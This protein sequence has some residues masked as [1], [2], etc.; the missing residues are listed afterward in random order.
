MFT[1]TYILKQL[2]CLA[3]RKAPHVETAS[4]T[5][6][7]F[8]GRQTKALFWNLYS[9]FDWNEV[10]NVPKCFFLQKVLHF[11]QRDAPHVLLLSIAAYCTR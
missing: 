7:M 4:I 2:A 6:E 3:T 5:A 8:S 11:W 1:G 10:E 9:E